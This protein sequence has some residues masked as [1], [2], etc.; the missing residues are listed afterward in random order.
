MKEK[1]GGKT[2]KGKKRK[3]GEDS[4]ES[5]EE[6]DGSQD[7][8]EEEKEGS[9]ASKKQKTVV[10]KIPAEWSKLIEEDSKNAITW[11]QVGRVD[12][13]FGVL[14]VTQTGE[15]EELED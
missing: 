10:F 9:Q 5:Q 8:Q 13:W 4:Q 3:A 1:E 11:A 15:G 12:F 2:G 14:N 7:S 6:E